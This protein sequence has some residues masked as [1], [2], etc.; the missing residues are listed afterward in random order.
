MSSERFENL[1]ERCY[2]EIS[3]IQSKIENAKKI[4]RNLEL[5]EKKTDTEIRIMN[6]N[7]D[8]YRDDPL[9]KAKENTNYTKDEIGYKN[10]DDF[11]KNMSRIEDGIWDR[12]IKEENYYGLLEGKIPI[13][14][15]KNDNPLYLNRKV[16]V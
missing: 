11:C 9:W 8:N 6:L 14:L 1:I 3:E 7:H 12:T 2:A 15:D 13:A 16:P 5:Y 4:I 10:W